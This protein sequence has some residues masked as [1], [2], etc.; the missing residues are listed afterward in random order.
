MGFRCFEELVLAV[1]PSRTALQVITVGET[2]SSRILA[3]HLVKT[4]E[5]I[6]PVVINPF[7][8]NKR[9]VYYVF[10]FNAFYQQGNINE[11][12]VLP[13]RET[14]KQ[15]ILNQMEVARSRSAVCHWWP[16]AQALTAELQDTASSS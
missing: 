5:N 13:T 9:L 14:N 6:F 16:L 3:F 8:T 12:C 2:G 15:S 4:P 1:S 11:V 10:F 7:S